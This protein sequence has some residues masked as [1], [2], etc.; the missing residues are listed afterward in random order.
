MPPMNGNP[1]SVGAV[2]QSEPGSPVGSYPQADRL[3]TIKG[4]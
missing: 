3:A 1:I 4:T 2:E